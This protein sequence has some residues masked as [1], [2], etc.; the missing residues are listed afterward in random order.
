MKEP[1]FTDTKGWTVKQFTDNRGDFY[2][3]RR[4][5]EWECWFRVTEILGPR[6]KVLY[7]Y[8]PEHK[9]VE[10]SDVLDRNDDF[11]HLRVVFAGWIDDAEERG[12]YGPRVLSGIREKLRKLEEVITGLR[13]EIEILRP[14]D[15]GTH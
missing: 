11:E 2:E 9:P 4:D 3:R 14:P 5:G 10:Y 12:I 7:R 1:A 13:V 6:K 15:L 8:R